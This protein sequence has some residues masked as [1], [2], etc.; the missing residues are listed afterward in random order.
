VLYGRVPAVRARRVSADDGASWWSS[1]SVAWQERAQGGRAGGGEVGEARGG[2]S[3][4][5]RW[6]HGALSALTEAVWRLVSWAL[7]VRSHSLAQQ[8]FVTP[9]HGLG[10]W[11]GV[12][13]PRTG[14]QYLRKY[15]GFGLYSAHISCAQSS[16]LTAPSPLAMR[17]PLHQSQPLARVTCGQSLAIPPYR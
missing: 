5:E 4:L 6:A 2:K 17:S 14:F 12:F 7:D 3:T 8:R 15:K 13:I 1:C 10:C 16:D 9:M 11:V